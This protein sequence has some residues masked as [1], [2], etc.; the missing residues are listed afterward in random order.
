[1]ALWTNANQI[2]VSQAASEEKRIVPQTATAETIKD[3][4]IGI[5]I[6][7]FLFTITVLSP[8]FGFFCTLFIPLPTLYYRTKL[9]R[10]Y[11]VIIPAATMFLLIVMLGGLSIDIVFFFELLFIGFVLGE[12]FELNLS[13]EKTVTYTCAA[14]LLIGIVVLLFYS[15]FS[16]TDIKT[17]ASEYVRKN[18]E[19]TIELYKS[20]GITPADVDIDPNSL[21]KIH[22]FFVRIVP[23]LVIAST[24]FLIWATLILSKPILVS[25]NLNY[26]GFG[27]LN[28]WKA[29]EYFV[30]VVIGCGLMLLIPK[31]SLKLLGTNGLLILMTIYFFQGIAIVAFFFDKKQLP[32]FFRIVL[33][34]LIAVQQLLLLI[35]I[36]LGFFDVWLNFRKLKT[37]K[38][39]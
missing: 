3:I 38:T 34:S 8:I 18:I 5:A 22:F 1:L 36:G 2:N 33:Y 39:D 32:R 10:K 14:V 35:V 24:L 4:S 29:P 9:G 30:W 6:T 12:F 15:S 37:A 23:A 11:G 27:P 20:M 7:S 13:V 17:L 26:P 25:R 28:L 31:I 21:E 19:L 16:A